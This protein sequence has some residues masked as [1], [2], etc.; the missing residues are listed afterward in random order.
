VERRVPLGTREPLVDLQRARVVVRGAASAVD[1]VLARR[2]VARVAPSN[3]AIPV[4]SRGATTAMM[5]GANNA[6]ISAERGDPISGVTPVLA[7]T[8]DLM[9]VREN[10]DASSGRLRDRHPVPATL[11]VQKTSRRLSIPLLIIQEPKILVFGLFKLH[12]VSAGAGW[13]LRV[14]SFGNLRHAPQNH[15]MSCA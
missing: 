4:P 5:G 10:N 7:V 12:C 6:A 2:D 15:R 11:P 3:A 8:T 9:A 1:A 14:G 13:R